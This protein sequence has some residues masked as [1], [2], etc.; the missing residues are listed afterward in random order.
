MENFKSIFF[1]KSGAANK[2]HIY[3]SN[4]GEELLEKLF[5]NRIKLWNVVLEVRGEDK[6]PEKNDDIKDRWH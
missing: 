6:W 5:I 3:Q 2:K 1:H 4:L